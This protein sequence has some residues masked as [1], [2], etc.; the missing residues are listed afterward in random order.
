MLWA[1]LSPITQYFMVYHDLLVMTGIMNICL[2]IQIQRIKPRV[3][4]IKTYHSPAGDVSRRAR[5]DG[6]RMTR[7]DTEE[8]EGARTYTNSTVKSVLSALFSRL[9]ALRSPEKCARK[10][11]LYI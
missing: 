2:E 4:P 5:T 8:H 6:Y 10:P 3:P 11:N 1:M 7:M 9:S